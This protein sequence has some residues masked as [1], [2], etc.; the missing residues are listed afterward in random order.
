MK[1]H[2]FK[3]EV[4]TWKEEERERGKIVVEASVHS[5]WTLEAESALKGTFNRFKG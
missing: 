4:K 3:G 2:L 5:L 1:L